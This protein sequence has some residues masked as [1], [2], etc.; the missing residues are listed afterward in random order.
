MQITPAMIRF[1]ELVGLKARI[2]K[3]SDPTLKNLMGSVVDE[4]KNT[5]KIYIKG[6][7]KTIPK[8]NSSFLF[9]LPDG[10]KV[11]IHGSLLVGRPE[12]RLSKLK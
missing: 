2:V 4:T 10:T 5:L 11:R 8:V 1:H 12:D 6:K 3:S 7:M 9:N